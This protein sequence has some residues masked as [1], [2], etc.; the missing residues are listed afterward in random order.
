ML[1]EKMLDYCKTPRQ[2]ELI[3][4]VIELD[5]IPEAAE[6]L[7]VSSSLVRRSVRRLKS[8]AAK[9]GYSPDNDMTKTVPDPYILKGTSTL[10]GEDGEQKLQ[11]VKTTLDQDK[12]IEV[13]EDAVRAIAEDVPRAEPIRPPVRG[14]QELMT[15]YPMGDPHFGMY[16]WAAECGDDFDLDI[17][18]QDLFGAVDYL[19]SVSPPS[20]VGVLMNLGDF[21]HAEN[22]AGVT[23]RSGHV[24]DMD[25]RFPRMLDVG[26][27][28]LRRCI[29]RMLEKHELVHVINV[30]GNHDEVLAFALNTMFRNLYENEPRI[31]VHDEPTQRHYVR[32]GRVLV[33][34]HH[35]H[36][37]KDPDLPILM[38]TE[39]PEDW[40]GT[41]HRFFFRGHHHHDR[42]IEYTG[43]TV[44]QVRTLAAGDSYAVG[45]GFLSGRDMKAITYHAAFGEQSRVVCGIDLLRS[46]S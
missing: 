12:R 27:R 26:F 31:Q 11:W 16:A 10:Y 15:V 32:H 9:S 4:K 6:A 44:E 18:E 20:K 42:R 39:K 5:S 43:C 14:A 17:A 29:T 40:G 19:V 3:E 22:M 46:A 23:T 35:G 28:A 25:T 30:P 41:A 45:S 37:T 33:G 8:T 34:A 13:V 7:G 36:R 2:R 24:L 21:F 38:A 1:D